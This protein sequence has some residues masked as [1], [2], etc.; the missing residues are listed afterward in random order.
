MKFTAV[1]LFLRQAAVPICRAIMSVFS[2]PYEL[3]SA[4]T[5]ILAPHQDDETLACGAL[6]AH[7]RHAG[8]EVHVVFLTDGGASHPGHPSLTVGELIC[9][10][11]QEALAAL[12]ILGVD[13]ACVQFWN[14]RDG[15]LNTL[16][17]AR[18]DALI[19]RLA[20]LLHTIK[21]G[22]L[23]VP[24]CPDGSSEHDPVLGL[25]QAAAA[26]AE[27]HPEIWQYPVW[28]WWN[29]LLLLS[30][31]FFQGGIHRLPGAEF[32]A[33][34]QK[35]LR[36]YHTQI[37]SIA[38]GLSPSVPPELREFCL[39]DSEYFFRTNPGPTPSLRRAR[40]TK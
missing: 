13:S 28:C 40:S 7:A 21:P 16:T 39:K 33:R 4:P 32:H 17:P 27:H 31:I 1:K 8:H 38:P 30:K 18:R 24:C 34:K 25:A 3:P 6:I 29:P 37:E 36:C 23:L 20:A 11:H 22:R 10:R 14:E 35:A 26:Q 15:T 9:L 5:L 12:E 2:R 19:T